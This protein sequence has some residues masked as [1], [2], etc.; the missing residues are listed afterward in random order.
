[1]LFRSNGVRSDGRL[2]PVKLGAFMQAV[3]SV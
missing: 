3:A 2:D 1:V